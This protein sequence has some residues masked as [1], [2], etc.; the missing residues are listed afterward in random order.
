MV[1]VSTL[2][3]SGPGTSGS[4]CGHSLAFALLPALEVCWLSMKARHCSY[5]QQGSRDQ[6]WCRELATAIQL[7]VPHRHFVVSA[8]DLIQR[9]MFTQHCSTSTMMPHKAG[10]YRRSL[11]R[12]AHSIYELDPITRGLSA[13]IVRQC[14]LHLKRAENAS[15]NGTTS[16]PSSDMPLLVTLSRSS[17]QQLGTCMKARMKLL[18]V[19]STHEPASAESQAAVL[20]YL[21]RSMPGCRYAQGKHGSEE[22]QEVAAVHL[23][24][25]HAVH[26]VLLF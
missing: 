11:L 17:L 19:L 14:A 2:L 15:E 23:H 16:Q 18:K 21:Q 10:C 12:N 8:V 26:V 9:E 24:L 5:I 22:Q 3:F 6:L 13:G 4:R 25:I 1:Q 20:S 7:A